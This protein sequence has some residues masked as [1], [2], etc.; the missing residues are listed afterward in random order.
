MKPPTWAGSVGCCDMCHTGLKTAGEF[1]DGRTRM[2]PWAML[3]TSCHEK[4]GVGL[5]A[6]KGQLYELQPNG[7]FLKTAG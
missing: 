5:G 1:V 2:G 6:G 7:T 3:C 4:Y